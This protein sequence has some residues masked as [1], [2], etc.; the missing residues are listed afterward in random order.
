MPINYRKVM[1][2]M[3]R[4]DVVNDKLIQEF[5]NSS[6]NVAF[7]TNYLDPQ[8]GKKDEYLSDKE[9]CRKNYASSLSLEEVKETVNKEIENF[10][11][12]ILRQCWSKLPVIVEA[13]IGRRYSH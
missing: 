10:H 6:W 2:D 9:W 13:K 5:P 3:R 4:K 7:I 11:F 1:R 12:D 8:T